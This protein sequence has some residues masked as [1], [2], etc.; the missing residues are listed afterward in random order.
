MKN[1]I[2]AVTL[3][4]LLA[5]CAESPAATTTP[6]STTTVPA[7][8]MPG[9]DAAIGSVQVTVTHPTI[10]PIVYTLDCFGDTFT[11]TPAVTGID[12][13]AACARFGDP[14]VIDRLVLGPPAGQI[15]TEI[16]GGEDLA[17]LTGT[18]N[19][20]PIDATID[21]TNGCGIADWDTLLAGILPPAIG[22]TS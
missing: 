7:R 22:V 1:L 4:S 2:L 19:D 12:A 6:A 10:D 20:E 18:I 17:V 11:V 15:C 13:A 8:L 3:G 21:R 14:A 16:Y 5:G 9:A